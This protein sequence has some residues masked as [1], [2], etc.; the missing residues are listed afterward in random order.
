LTDLPPLKNKKRRYNEE[1]EEPKD[2]MEGLRDATT[3]YVGNL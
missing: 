2:P 3:L 1:P